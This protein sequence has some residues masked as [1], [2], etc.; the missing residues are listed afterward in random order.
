MQEVRKAFRVLYCFIISVILCT[1]FRN[2]R[3]TKQHTQPRSVNS[4][5][6]HTQPTSLSRNGELPEK[7]R[8]NLEP[9][10]TIIV[11]EKEV[12]NIMKQ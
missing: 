7:G 11:E 8:L 10:G 3:N 9:K 6:Q 2:L 4:N 5:K 12:K 1:M